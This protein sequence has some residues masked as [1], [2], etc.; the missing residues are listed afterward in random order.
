MRNSD[1]TLKFDLSAVCTILPERIPWNYRL[2]PSEK[3]LDRATLTASCYRSPILNG[4]D[5]TQWIDLA[6]HWFKVGV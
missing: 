1:I 4:T 3:Q 5:I 6:K 2:L